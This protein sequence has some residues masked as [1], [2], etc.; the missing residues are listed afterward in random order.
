[1][2]TY[3]KQKPNAVIQYISQGQVYSG[4][5]LVTGIVNKTVNSWVSN[6]KGLS[7]EDDSVIVWDSVDKS[8]SVT[9]LS[10]IPITTPED[11]EKFLAKLGIIFPIEAWSKLKEEQQKEFTIAVA[12][13]KEYL[14]KAKQIKSIQKNTLD[15]MLHITIRHVQRTVLYAFKLYS[16]DTFVNI[17]TNFLSIAVYSSP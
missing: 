2:Q 4:S 1:M 11:K 3:T 10:G 5:A 12:S 9:D 7:K 8:Y 13:I 17:T 6:L 16:K 15:V 14:Q